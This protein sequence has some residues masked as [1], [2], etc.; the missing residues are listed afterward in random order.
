MGGE[1]GTVDGGGGGGV[2]DGENLHYLL[3]SEHN[4]KILHQKKTGIQIPGFGD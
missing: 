2:G 4:S 1:G 3:A